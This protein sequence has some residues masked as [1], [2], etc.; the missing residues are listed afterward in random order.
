MRVQIQGQNPQLARRV[1]EETHLPLAALAVF[2]CLGSVPSRVQP[3]LENPVRELARIAA[4]A[5]TVAAILWANGAGVVVPPRV[6]AAR[7]LAR[8][9]K[10]AVGPVVAA[11][12]RAA[13]DL[14]LVHAEVV[15]GVRVVGVFIVGR[16][17]QLVLREVLVEERLVGEH[18]GDG[19]STV[20]CGCGDGSSAGEE[21][22]WWDVNVP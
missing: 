16:V 5:H 13:A 21:L 15:G 7:L 6:A 22:P 2:A 18:V 17:C 8:V 19:G 3:A 12:A 1:R 9:G 14:E 10:R 11:A 4:A 20:V